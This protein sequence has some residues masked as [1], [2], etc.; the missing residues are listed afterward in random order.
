VFQYYVVVFGIGV[1]SRV[2]D[3]INVFYHLLVFSMWVG[4][5]PNSPFVTPDDGR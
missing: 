1:V 3:G 5:C 4:L 2:Y